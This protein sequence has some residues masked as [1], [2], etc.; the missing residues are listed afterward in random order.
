[1]SAAP[2]PA[3]GPAACGIEWIVEAFGCEPERLRSERAVRE[4]FERAVAELVLNPL[5]PPAFHAF[6]SPG[7][8]TGFVLLSESH[9]ACHTFPETGYAAINLYCCRERPRWDFAARCRELL[10]ARRTEV[11]E[12]RRGGLPDASP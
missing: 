5:S 6:P 9:L 10:G 3:S 2:D 7:G 4:L 12:V 1:M 11:R 8:V